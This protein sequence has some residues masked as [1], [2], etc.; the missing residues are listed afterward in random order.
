[1]IND[2][3]IFMIRIIL[4]FHY[5]MLENLEIERVSRNLRI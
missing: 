3:Y 1:M 4:K 2:I 5:L